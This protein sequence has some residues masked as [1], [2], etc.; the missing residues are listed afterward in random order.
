MGG[1]IISILLCI[2]GV[3]FGLIGIVIVSTIGFAII[4]SAMNSYYEKGSE[5][6]L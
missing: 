6:S 5:E 2:V 4:A 1:V 3:L